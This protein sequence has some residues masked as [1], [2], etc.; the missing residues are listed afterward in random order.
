MFSM[1]ESG[2]VT[3]PLSA[4]STVDNRI[5]MREYVLQLLLKSFPNLSN[6]GVHQFVVGMFEK[7]DFEAFCNHLRDF[8]VE[9]KEFND[10]DS[11]KELYSAE[12]EVYILLHSEIVLTLHDIVIAI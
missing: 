3:A 5:F 11:N 8:L 6:Q 12:D 1:V 4:D 9:L 10:G 2:R 7:T